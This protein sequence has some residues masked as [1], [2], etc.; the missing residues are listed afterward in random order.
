M[1][2]ESE[3]ATLH[4]VGGSAAVDNLSACL[5]AT[6]PGD[7]VLLTGDA[8][9]AALGANG[10]GALAATPPDVRV[11]AL[12]RDADERG[13]SLRIAARLNLIDDHEMVRYSVACARSLS[14]F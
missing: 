3:T 4:L 7:I 11:V 14:W 9:L 6:R 12:A 10:A 2:S 8:V 5:D 13:V 1:S